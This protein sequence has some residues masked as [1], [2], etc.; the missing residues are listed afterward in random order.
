MPLR[1]DHDDLQMPHEDFTG[2]SGGG[3]SPRYWL[4]LSPGEY[5]HGETPAGAAILDA[6]TVLERNNASRLLVQHPGRGTERGWR[7]ALGT[8]LANAYDDPLRVSPAFLVIT[9]RPYVEFSGE[10]HPFG[11]IDLGDLVG[12]GG[13]VNR[14]ELAGL[15]A[16]LETW[17]EAEPSAFD[18]MPAPKAA[19]GG[20]TDAV[21]LRPGVFGFRLDLRK[22][23]A[24]A[25]SRR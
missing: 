18:D 2:G 4:I 1:F 6:L 5:F 13:E 8:K 9:R 22:L 23:H 7:Q 20:W 21:E 14:V 16:S 11:L 12:A 15:L 24:W 3:A 10:V 25:R 17:L 19:S